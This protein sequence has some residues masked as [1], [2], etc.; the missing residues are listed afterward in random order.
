MTGHITIVV[1]C[2]TVSTRHFSCVAHSLPVLPLGSVYTTVKMAATVTFTAMF[3]NMKV[4]FTSITSEQKQNG[5]RGYRTSGSRTCVSCGRTWGRF[6]V[7]GNRT[8]TY[9]ISECQK[10]RSG[11]SARP[12]TS[13]SRKPLPNCDNHLSQQRGLPLYCTG[14]LKLVFFQNWQHCIPLASQQ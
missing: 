4:L 6:M 2:I 10:I 3:R 9:S 12:M 7:I 1:Q 5:Y 13:I 11:I 8:A 14:W